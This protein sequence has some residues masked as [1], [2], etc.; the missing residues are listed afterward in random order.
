M[1]YVIICMSTGIISIVLYLFLRLY[2]EIYKINLFTLICAILVSIYL[3]L[4]TLIA[5]LILDT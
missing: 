3:Y 5:V 4:L 2:D 1:K